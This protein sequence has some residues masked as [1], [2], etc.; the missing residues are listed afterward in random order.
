MVTVTIMVMMATLR[1]YPLLTLTLGPLERDFAYVNVFFVCA[2]ALQYLAIFAL[3]R[4]LGESG[5]GARVAR[6]GDG[7][8][9]AVKASGAPSATTAEEEEAIAV[10]AL[11]GAP[12]LALRETPAVEPGGAAFCPPRGGVGVVEE[13]EVELAAG[14]DSGGAMAV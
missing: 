9:N 13:G 11:L 3:H 2:T 1:Q 10:D 6:G 4:R 7:D 14:G 8:G 12:Q 5:G